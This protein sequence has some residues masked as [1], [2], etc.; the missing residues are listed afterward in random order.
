MKLTLLKSKIHRATVTQANI[1]YEGSVSIDQDLLDAADILSYEAVD[2]WD[3]TNGQ[4]LRTYAIS[5]ERGTGE[6][7][8][9]GAAAHLVKP[10][11]LVIIA[12]WAEM[13]EK[14]ARRHEAIRVFVDGANRPRD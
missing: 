3:C 4:R 1:E 13:S 7:C 12:S 2:I 9:N 6:I 5:G 10:G 8:V 11:D 14:K